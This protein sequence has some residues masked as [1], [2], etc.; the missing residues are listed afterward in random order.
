MCALGQGIVLGTNRPYRR[1]TT[2]QRS[3]PRW[4]PRVR[5]L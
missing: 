1:P 3:H 5:S 2:N 4:M